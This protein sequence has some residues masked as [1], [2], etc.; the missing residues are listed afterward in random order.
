MQLSPA[1]KE[2]IFE[3]IKKGTHD[4]RTICR[5]HALN[6]RSK[7]YTLA[8]VADILEIT[9]R[10]VFNIECY[11]EQGGLERALYD[12][13]RPGAPIIYDDKVKSHIVALVCSDPPDAFDHWT[14]ELIQEKVIKDGVVKS[15]SRE[16]VRVILQEHDLKPWRQRSWCV[17][18]LDDEFIE[19]MEDVLG[20]YEKGHSPDRPLVCLDEKPIQLLDDVRPASG[21]TPGEIKKVDFEYK[22]NGTANVFCAVVPQTGEYINRVTERRTG[23]DFAKFL[24][25]IERRFAEAKKIVLI[26]DNLKTH[27]LKSLTD[28]YG[29]AEGTRIWERFEV[30]FTPKHGSWLN[31]AEIAINV[32][33]RQCFGKIRIPDIETLRKKTKSWNAI[34]NRH[35]VTIKWNFTRK[36]ARDKFHYG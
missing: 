35:K 32:Y 12:D 13:P 1:D 19:R 20:V 8:E 30:H 18:D 27:S 29:E 14:L 34:A 7:Q 16:T 10:T 28:F 36:D 6:L 3:I 9:P 25:S 5:A 21:I 31:Q 4:A 11:Y 2:K 17:A 26:M 24:A 15:I 22:R 33:S 23:A